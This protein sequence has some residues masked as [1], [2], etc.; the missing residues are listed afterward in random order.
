MSCVWGECGDVSV[1][2]IVGFC[3]VCVGCRWGAGSVC[4]MSGVGG[5][6]GAVGGV[7]LGGIQCV[8]GEYGVCIWGGLYSVVGCECVG[9]C[10]CACVCVCDACRGVW[11][12]GVWCV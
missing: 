2:G 3:G 7:S 8:W 5:M 6:Y 12:G 1:G 10:A 9:A 4:G 11:V